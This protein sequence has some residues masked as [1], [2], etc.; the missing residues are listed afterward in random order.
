[1]SRS[2]IVSLGLQFNAALQ[3]MGLRLARYPSPADRRR[4]QLMRTHAIN[5][6]IDIGANAGQYGKLL[7]RLGYTHRIVSYEPL[8]EAY[9]R[10]KATAR[11]DDSWTVLQKAV[12]EASGRVIMKVA[13][14]SVSSSIL[15]MAPRHVEAAPESDVVGSIAVDC[16]SL[17]EILTEWRDEAL[18]VKIDTQGYERSILA[19]GSNTI[20]SVSMFEIE[21]SFVELYYGQ[22]LFREIDSFMI[23]SGFKLSSLEEGFFDERTGELLQCDAIYIRQ[24]S[25]PDHTLVSQT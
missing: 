12:G 17:D 16:V 1:M 15:E 8:P 24:N 18:M 13:G 3:R 11:S 25:V 4:I 10:L 19:S 23:S 20:R 22:A 21:A 14:N 2:L 7:R 6:V 5:T 9:D